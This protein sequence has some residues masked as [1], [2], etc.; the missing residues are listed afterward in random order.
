MEPH[1]EVEVPLQREPVCFLLF[2]LKA[3]IFTQLEGPTNAN[4]YKR[5]QEAEAW[6]C[7]NFHQLHCPSLDMV[8]GNL[9]WSWMV[10]QNGGCGL[11]PSDYC[12]PIP[13]QARQEA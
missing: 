9:G 7:Q 12:F 10:F 1:K 11:G 5:P 6:A 8:L 4:W 3:T 13:T 2:P